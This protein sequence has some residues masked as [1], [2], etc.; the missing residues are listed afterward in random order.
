VI[1]D[2]PTTITVP[3]FPEGTWLFGD[4][5]SLD[6]G[7]NITDSSLNEVNNRQ[8][9]METFETTFFRGCESLAVDIPLGIDCICPPA[10]T[11]A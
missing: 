6:L 3:V 1:V 11:S 10:T 2:Y 9:F 5:G 7:T 8:A 4:G